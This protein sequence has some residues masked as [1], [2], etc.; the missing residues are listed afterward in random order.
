MDEFPV[1][2]HNEPFGCTDFTYIQILTPMGSIRMQ[3]E[4]AEDL[5][6]RLLAA[7]EYEDGR[8]ETYMT[9]MAREVSPLRLHAIRCLAR[10]LMASNDDRLWGVSLAIEQLCTGAI[11]ADQAFAQVEGV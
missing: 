4:E 8:N 10:C 7:S 9:L 5:G 3:G 6:R 11:T 2:V 1:S